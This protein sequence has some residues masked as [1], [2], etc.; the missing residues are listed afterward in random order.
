MK[1]TQIDDASRKHRFL[2]IMETCTALSMSVFIALSFFV[3][4]GRMVVPEGK[5]G[6]FDPFMVPSILFLLLTVVLALI[7]RFCGKRVIAKGARSAL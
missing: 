2:R 4:L 7:A 3:V 1:T 6:A 5:P